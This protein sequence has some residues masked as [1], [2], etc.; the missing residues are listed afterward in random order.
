MRA[1]GRVVEI[2]KRDIWSAARVAAQRPDLHYHHL[3]IDFFPPAVVQAGL[4]R[5][6]VPRLLQRL[7]SLQLHFL[8]EGFMAGGHQPPASI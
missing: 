8:C 3:A 4:L 2:G 6:S 1:G 7:A 5:V